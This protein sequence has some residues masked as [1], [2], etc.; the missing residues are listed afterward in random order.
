MAEVCPKNRA[1]F[2]HL[3]GVGERKL[4][5]YGDVF[6]NAIQEYLQESK[7]NLQDKDKD[8]DSNNE[9]EVILE[10]ITKPKHIIDSSFANFPSTESNNSSTSVIEAEANEQKVMITDKIPS[11]IV[12]YTMYQE[13]K[14]LEEISKLRKYK[15]TT[16]QDHIIRAF[17]DGYSL[18]LKDFIPTGQEQLILDVIKRVGREKLRPIKDALPDEVDW[19]TIKVVLAK[20]Y[21]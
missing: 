8:K 16:I 21:R 7:L 15:L 13:G 11:H 12:T 1:A 20:N 3:S 18:A 6:L 19:M 14:T 2:I 10:K 4:E 5:K 9:D 17:Q